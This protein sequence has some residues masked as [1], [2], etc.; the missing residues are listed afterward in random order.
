[1]QFMGYNT[2]MC[3]DLNNRWSLEHSPYI[4]EADTNKTFDPILRSKDVLVHF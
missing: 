2:K 3:K 1:M 4:V